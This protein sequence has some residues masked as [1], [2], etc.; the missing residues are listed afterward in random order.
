MT[1]RLPESKSMK[2]TKSN[3]LALSKLVMSLILVLVLV[4]TSALVSV[5]SARELSEAAAIFD[6]AQ[7][8]IVTVLGGGHGSGFLV[9]NDGLILTNNHVI[10]GS[11][12]I[13][14]RFGAGQTM[15][16]DV[17]AVDR[18][19]DIAVLAVN[20]QNIRKFKALK[21]SKNEP[22][23]MMGE[24]VIAIGSPV[25]WETNEKTMTT[26]VVGKISDY[27]ISH[28]A[29]INGGNSGGP[30]LNYDG[31]VVG[32]NTFGLAD[33]GPSI[34]NAVSI[35]HAAKVVQEAIEKRKTVPLPSP[36]LHMEASNIEFPYKTVSF[37]NIKKEPK[38]KDYVLHSKY[39]DIVIGPQMQQYREVVRYDE[40]MLKSRKK[41]ASEKGFTV[42][43][44]EYASKNIGDYN[45]KLFSLTKPVATV[46]V[47]PKP[48]L[49]GGAAF[50]KGF[51]TLGE[52]ALA[53]FTGV[54]VGASRFVGNTREVKKDF[55]D[56]SLVDASGNVVCEPILRNRFDATDE[57]AK[58]FSFMYLSNFKDK[59]FI[60]SYEYDP[61]CFNKP[62]AKSFKVI[63]EG[64]EK[65]SLIPF[66][67]KAELIV[68]N[69]FEPY[70]KL[71]ATPLK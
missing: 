16:A 36:K 51:A 4:M 31:E 9:T 60:G 70:Y 33:R 37:A 52:A 67:P 65:N 19:K 15:D 8:G 30:L 20:L 44:D 47:I 12:F 53:G 55:E 62:G 40:E 71:L 17:L 57:L 27:V 63:T 54:Y 68:K 39:F 10:N 38:L 2:S 23:V 45:G 61:S 66:K 26:G 21:L 49:T 6:E 41:R 50:R 5:V 46:L 22:L 58:T 48:Q 64:D 14:V 1:A 24:K 35:K 7:Y 69:D 13:T 25:N 42:S 59:I 32:I 43:D 29:S 56:M 28:D 11:K 34:G 3:S 18:E